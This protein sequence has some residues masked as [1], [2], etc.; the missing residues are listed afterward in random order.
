MF[1]F[2]G[3][4]GERQKARKKK[5]KKQREETR[6]ILVTESEDFVI[7]WNVNGTSGGEVTT[8]S[9]SVIPLTFVSFIQCVI[10]DVVQLLVF[11]VG[12]RATEQLAFWQLQVAIAIA[13]RGILLTKSENSVV[14]WNINGT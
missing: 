13:T 11:K 10:G 3:L 1:T 2:G 6:N 7:P 5:L 8:N 9:E 14:P 12:G 4:S